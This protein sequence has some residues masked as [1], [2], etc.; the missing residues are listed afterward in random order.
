MLKHSIHPKHRGAKKSYLLFALVAVVILAAL[1]LFIFLSPKPLAHGDVE[2]YVLKAN[3]CVDCF[4]VLRIVEKIHVWGVNI[5]KV[6]QFD[7]SSA[8]GKALVREFAIERSPS[9]VIM[10]NNETLYS[11]LVFWRQYGVLRNGALVL[12]KQRPVFIE[13]SSGEEIGRVK[14]TR[15]LPSKCP[16]CGNLSSFIDGLKSSGISISSDTILFDYQA[17]GLISRYNISVLPAAI[18][19]PQAQSYD[20]LVSS[21]HNLGSVETDGSFVLR[22]SSVPGWYVKEK[23]IRGLVNATLITTSTCANCYAPSYHV[24]LLG[25]KRGF[26]VIFGSVVNIDAS[27][28]QGKDVIARYNVTKIPTVIL[29]GDVKAYPSLL[30]FW[31]S[32]GSVESDGS[33]V[34]R[35]FNAIPGKSYLDLPSGKILSE[36]SS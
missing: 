14:I 24:Q 34:F 20:F 25:S 33:L 23:S 32:L 7:L 15:I 26:G 18:L 13:L 29:Q 19:S 16:S 17:L 36:S 11:L 21:W 4:D 27:S 1:F 30:E 35:N 9:I 28:V 12:T 5:T 22:E 31:S 10:A 8:E 6:H 3:S 2:V